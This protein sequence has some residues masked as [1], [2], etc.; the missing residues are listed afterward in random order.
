MTAP[1]I[2]YVNRHV[3]TNC[4]RFFAQQSRFNTTDK[5]RLVEPNQQSLNDAATSLGIVSEGQEL[6]PEALRAWAELQGAW[7]TGELGRDE[8]FVKVS[9]QSK[10]ELTGEYN[11]DCNMLLD[12]LA[13]EKSKVDRI[14]AKAVDKMLHLDPVSDEHQRGG[15]DAIRSMIEMIDSVEVE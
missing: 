8:E 12:L 14:R 6:T 3:R 5:Y 9:K 13:A 1:K 10:R 15:R 11:A 7:V 4:D 2:L